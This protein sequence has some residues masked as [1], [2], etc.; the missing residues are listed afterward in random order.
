MRPR[1][2]RL[3][4]RKDSI[5]RV[6]GCSGPRLTLKVDSMSSRNRRASS[7]LSRTSKALAT[8][9]SC[10]RRGSAVKAKDP[11]HPPKLSLGRCKNLIRIALCVGFQTPTQRPSAHRPL[12]PLRPI[13]PTSIFRSHRRESTGSCPPTPGRDTRLVGTETLAQGRFSGFFYPGGAKNSKAMLSGS[14]KDKPE[15]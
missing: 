6:S 12:Q 9:T 15:P 4:A 13:P 8:L 7:H 3:M 14:R 11:N 10:H 1:C 5:V 2:R